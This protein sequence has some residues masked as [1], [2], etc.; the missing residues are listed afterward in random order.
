MMYKA[1]YYSHE[2]R[3][4]ETITQ[5]FEGN[6]YEEIAADYFDIYGDTLGRLTNENGIVVYDNMEQA[7][8]E[9]DYWRDL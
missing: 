2:T 1:E 5:D 3:D 4:F 7:E 8:D 9:R 6:S